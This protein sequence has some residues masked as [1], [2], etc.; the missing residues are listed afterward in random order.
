MASI[1]TKKIIVIDDEKDFSSALS[2]YLNEQG[3]DADSFLNVS[4]ARAHLRREPNP[5][6][7][8]LD[9]VMP[10]GD[11]LLFLKEIRANH[12]TKD[13]PVI[14]MSAHRTKSQDRVA[15]LEFGANDYILK[16]FDM[17]EVLL[18]IQR[19]INKPRHESL[20][21]KKAAP[22]PA[23]KGASQEEAVPHQ[24]PF[25]NPE[26]SDF[27]SPFS[28]FSKSIA[29]YPLPTESEPK[30]IIRE[31]FQLTLAPLAWIK[32]WLW[33]PRL[34]I[35]FFVVGLTSLFIGLQMG[36]ED[37]SMGMTLVGTL[38][39]GALLFGLA[40]LLAW[41]IQWIWGLRQRAVSFKPLM[42]LF[43]LA[44]TPILVSSLM[45]VFYVG[46]GQGRAFEFTAGPLLLLVSQASS[47][48]FG[49]F[50]R[51]LD[52]FELAGLFI[53]LKGL[54][55]FLKVEFKKVAI[56]G[57]GLW[58]LFVFVGTLLPHIFKP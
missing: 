18:R 41:L 57:V 45:G 24:N 39:F 31:I 23:P 33:D 29:P 8:L 30:K 40:A 32:S 58:A 3:Y 7:I 1:T 52:F 14:I 20:S 34:K 53:L 54:S 28:P 42:G 17:K 13:I 50:L 46:F 12:K 16:P 9:V 51:R 37:R 43:C 10:D 22:F 26:K 55:L 36:L 6:L 44:L 21:E 38:I 4:S 19:E 47:K 2:D 35:P 25:A 5:A 49:F 56:W 27:S 48:Y 11:G 15:G